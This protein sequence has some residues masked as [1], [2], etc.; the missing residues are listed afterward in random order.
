MVGPDAG[1]T[2]PRRVGWDGF[3]WCVEQAS[4]NV[5][6]AAVFFHSPLIMH[7][8]HVPLSKGFC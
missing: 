7:G 1:G 3:S 5:S 8:V 4:G 6:A 2:K